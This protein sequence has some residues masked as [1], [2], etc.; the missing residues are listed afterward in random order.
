MFCA[1]TDARVIVLRLLCTCFTNEYLFISTHFFR[2]L[3][4]EVV[5][6]ID[7]DDV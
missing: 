6:H 1:M 4:T 7:N 3:A 5:K 2:C